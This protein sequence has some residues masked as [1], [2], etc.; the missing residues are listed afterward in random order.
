MLCRRTCRI[1]CLFSSSPCRLES[2]ACRLIFS[3]FLFKFCIWRLPRSAYRSWRSFEQLIS[4]GGRVVACT[5]IGFFL[6]CA[7]NRRR[8][9]GVSD[10]A[11][12][13][14]ADRSE[15]VD[16]S[17]PVMTGPADRSECVDASMSFGTVMEAGVWVSMFGKVWSCLDSRE[18]LRNANKDPVKGKTRK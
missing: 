6:C 2:S 7:R 13:G 12:T 11:M 1:A 8:I 10:P 14:P 15:Y 3:L 9:F 5:V 16:V 17:D 4:F 18:V